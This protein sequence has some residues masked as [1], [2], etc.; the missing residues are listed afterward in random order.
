[1]VGKIRG[2]ASIESEV[3]ARKMTDGESAD[4]ENDQLACVEEINENKTN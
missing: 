2:K 1:M 3:E 4:D